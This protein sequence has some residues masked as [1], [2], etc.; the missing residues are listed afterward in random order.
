MRTYAL[1]LKVLTANDPPTLKKLQSFEYHKISVPVMMQDSYQP[2]IQQENSGQMAL[3]SIYG[4]P[5]M[6]LGFLPPTPMLEHSK[7][8]CHLQPRCVMA[9]ETKPSPTPQGFQ[10]PLILNPKLT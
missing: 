9:S 6:S 7:P 8:P 5:I 1:T 4:L 3:D 10:R 2:D